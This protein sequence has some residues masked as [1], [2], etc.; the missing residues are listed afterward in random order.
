MYIDYI[1]FLPFITILGF[2]WQFFFK[3]NFFSVISK[4]LKNE[5]IKI[6]E[7]NWK[8]VNNFI[9]KINY[10][11]LI[12]IYIYIFLFKG[13][14]EYFWWNHFY[15]NIFNLNL[16]EFYFLL[17]IIFYFSISCF[18]KIYEN[19][20]N[21]YFFALIFLTL[22]SLYI[23]FSNTFFTFIFILECIS[24]TIFF[25]FISSKIWVID[26]FQKLDLK[27]NISFKKYLNM[28]FFQF[29]STFFS[30][31]IIFFFL[32]YLI[33]NFG[34]TE[35]FFFNF[36]FELK[37]N[38]FFNSDFLFSF[39][40]F[41]FFFFAFFVKIGFT[42]L[43]L[44]KV[45]LYKGLSFITIFFYTTIYF[46]VYFTFFLL[47]IYFYFNSFFNYIYIFFLFI[48]LFSFIYLIMYI[49]DINTS[50]SFFAFSTISNSLIFFLL[51]ISS[52]V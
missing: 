7:I 44:Y 27:K 48:I 20:K 33:F 21:D 38:F 37:Y 25:K 34:T 11:S 47:F 42:P 52:F 15:T 23:Y 6:Y 51:S 30:T 4:K 22:F 41:S 2:Y 28:I 46:L 18:F 35:W 50:K 12:Y 26:N 32:I 19:L 13:Y 39:F 8:L 43:H 29:W 3:V 16:I 14:E 49:F 9:N 40:L 1:F 45:E 10:I 36:L 17:F 5:L 24:I 31:I